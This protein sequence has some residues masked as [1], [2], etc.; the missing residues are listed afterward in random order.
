[1]RNETQKTLIFLGVA[2]LAMVVAWLAW[3]TDDPLGKPA[4]MVGK[5][6]V[7]PGD[8]ASTLDDATGI[9]IVRWDDVDQKPFRFAVREGEDGRWTIPSHS[10]Y[11]ADAKEQFGKAA[12]AL[13]GVNI[14]SVAG[15]SPSQHATFGLLDPETQAEGGV[16]ADQIGTRITFRD[17][18]GKEIVDLIVGKEDREQPGTRYVRY[19]DRDM[20]YQIE[21]DLTQF[22]TDFQNW[23]E[24]DLLQADGMLNLSGVTIDDYSIEGNRKIDRSTLM[25]SYS[26]RA[27]PRW[28]LDYAV[29]YD[30]KGTPVPVEL[31]AEEELAVGTLDTLR[32]SLGELAI[33][34]VRRKPECVQK[35]LR[36]E[37][38][39]DA[40]AAEFQLDLQT[41]G[42]FLAERP[43][44]GVGL[45][46]SEGQIQA[47]MNDGVTYVLQFGRLTTV[48][49]ENLD[50]VGA[51]DETTTDVAGEPGKNRY[52]FV[53]VAFNPDSVEKPSIQP[54]PEPP[55][56][57][58]DD[59]DEATRKTY[60]EALAAHNAEKTRIE[61]ANSAKQQE[62]DSR[63][64]EG[65]KRVETLRN[66]FSDWYYV[67]SDAEYQKIHLTWEKIVRKKTAPEG[68][69]AE[70]QDAHT[71]QELH[72][73][74]LDFGKM[75]ED[76]ETAKKARETTETPVGTEDVA[77]ESPAPE[78]PVEESPAPET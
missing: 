6:V 36:Q 39:T 65:E 25:L 9:E 73:E 56:T 77:E 78:A 18:D 43:G 29:R 67:V 57:P 8:G 40:E 17:G 51:S 45:Y 60:D 30:D 7:S 68:E 49:G 27:D 32:A 54:I 63:I 69:N 71:P 61:A 31:G 5:S 58:A 44:G 28:S 12:A 16:P 74:V 1:M 48:K 15:D 55:A 34:D 13:T 66:R 62:Y 76:A 75:I 23:I 26:D 46:S 59:A 3:P 72:S 2:I 42:F 24:K 11:P 22:S 41:R 20:V 33:V 4:D 10:D 14:L 19:A 52:L 35:V 53:R 38:I 70:E 50:A 37:P 47:D 21:L 64:A